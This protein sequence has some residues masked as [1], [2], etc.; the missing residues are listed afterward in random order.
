M[1]NSPA[2]QTSKITKGERRDAKAA[3]KADIKDIKANRQEEK[4]ASKQIHKRSKQEERTKRIG[5]RQGERTR[6]VEARHSSPA[7]QT[8][9]VDPMLTNAHRMPVDPMQQQPVQAPNPMMPNR[10]GAPPRSMNNLVHQPLSTQG[11]MAY[12]KGKTPTKGGVGGV[13][14]LMSDEPLK[15]G[16]PDYI[17]PENRE[18]PGMTR[19]SDTK[20]LS[21][22]T[23]KK[24]NQGIYDNPS[25]ALKKEKWMQ[26]LDIEKGGL[27]KSLGIPMDEK[28]PYEDK[29][30]ASQSSNPKIKKQGILALNFLEAKRK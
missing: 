18:K 15:P 2:K 26:D 21:D 22:S 7:K 5:I 11:S 3:M 28:I 6:R 24:L 29:V 23:R 20:T 8:G 9:M 19:F 17:L 30:K 14:N 10:A 13:S 27:H 25:I 12:Q 4:D 16:H 1:E